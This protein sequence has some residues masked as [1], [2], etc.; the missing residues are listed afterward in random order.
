MKRFFVYFAVLT[1]IVFMVGCGGSGSSEKNYEKD[2]GG[3][4]SQEEE[5]KYKC[6]DGA[7]YRCSC[8]EM[9]YETGDCKKYLWQ[10]PITCSGG[11]NE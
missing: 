3:T 4:C 10:N 6:M 11:C 8:A 9:D 2:N 1:A 7:S 5:D